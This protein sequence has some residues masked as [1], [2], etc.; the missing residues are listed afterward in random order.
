[1]FRL[2]GK[3]LMTAEVAAAMSLSVHTVETYRQRIK[4]KLSLRTCRGTCTSRI[5]VGS[6]KWVTVALA[7]KRIIDRKP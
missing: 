6:G 1:M 2:I 7:K 4:A 5:P 3:G